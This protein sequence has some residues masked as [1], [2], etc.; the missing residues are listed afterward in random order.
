[1]VSTEKSTREYLVEEYQLSLVEA[2][3]TAKAMET[4]V[5]IAKREKEE[6]LF[7][8]AEELLKLNILNDEY[9]KDYIELG[10]KISVKTT[11]IEK[12]YDIEINEYSLRA[13]RAASERIKKV[14]DEELLKE[15]R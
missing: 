12:L 6:E 1:M 13:I 8:D 5:D 2:E 11:E 3:D 9:S 4:P 14:Y 7:A 15:E 10:N